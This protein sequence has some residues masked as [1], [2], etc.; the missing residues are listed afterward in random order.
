LPTAAPS[1]FRATAT[2]SRTE[3]Y[4]QLLIVVVGRSRSAP[5]ATCSHSVDFS[6]NARRA[7]RRTSDSARFRRAPN[8]RPKGS[9]RSQQEI[10]KETL[11][12][13]VFFTFT[14]VALETGTAQCN[15]A[16]TR[17]LF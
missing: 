3:S 4:T 1:P 2:Y 17:R 7:E 16:T 12:P 8:A 15:S 14:T 9:R 10:C 13:S 5:P 6:G 11:P